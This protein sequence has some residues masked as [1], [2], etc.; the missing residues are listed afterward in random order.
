MK[1]FFLEDS[2]ELCIF[3]LREK[4]W[5]NYGNNSFHTLDHGEEHAEL[6]KSITQPTRLKDQATDTTDYYTCTSFISRHRA[7]SLLAPK[8]CQR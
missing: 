2:G 1:V 3:V 4:G 5:S 7:V 8:S 6:H